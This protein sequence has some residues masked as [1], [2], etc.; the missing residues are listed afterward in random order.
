M[1]QSLATSVAIILGATVAI[2]VGSGWLESAGEQLSRYYGLPL[3]VQGAI[4]AAIGSSCPELAS[5]V[6]AALL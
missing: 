6:F 5:V 4:V 1:S 3:V 2:Y